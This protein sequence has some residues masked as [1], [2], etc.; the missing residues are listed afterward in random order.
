MTNKAYISK[1]VLLS[2]LEAQ[3]EEL[4]LKRLLEFLDSN[5]VIKNQ[6]N[7]EYQH[8]Y[9]YYNY[10]NCGICKLARNIAKKFRDKKLPIYL[11]D[12]FANRFFLRYKADTTYGHRE[13]F[14]FLED[15]IQNV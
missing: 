9:Y 2:Y 5:K 15:Q 3:N 8:G 10:C 1:R 12:R 11:I 4:P 13:F 7:R 6:N 14:K